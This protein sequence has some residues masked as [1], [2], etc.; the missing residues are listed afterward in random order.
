[1]RYQMFL[2]GAKQDDDAAMLHFW[3]RG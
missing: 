1:V 2:K 3:T